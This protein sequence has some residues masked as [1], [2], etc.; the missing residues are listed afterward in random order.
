MKRN[1]CRLI[2][3][4]AREEF[5]PYKTGV[6]RLLRSNQSETVP[7]FS[8]VLIHGGGTDN[9]AISWYK[10]FEPFGKCYSVTALD[11][12]GFGATKGIELLGG[13]DK[14][15]DFTVEIMKLA[16]INKAVVFGV[17]MGG[18]VALNIAL[19]HTSF[20]EALVLVGPG[21]LVPLIKN[22]VLHTSAWLGTK[23]PDWLLLPLSQFANRFV[24]SVLKNMVH[25]YA[26]LPP[27]VVDEFIREAQKRGAGMGYGRYNQATVG[28]YGMKNNLLPLVGSIEVPALFFHGKNDPM[29]DPAGSVKAVNSMPN[30][31]LV[32]PEDCGH[33]AQLEKHEL[34]VHEVER[35]LQGMVY[36]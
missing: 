28:R 29:V 26:A 22:K 23:L 20:T 19:R 5:I 34:F 18:D 12:P 6:V 21:G 1:T 14:M 9:A 4:G 13:P 35:F 24:K 27:E 10:L 2:P 16:D 15:A 7:E 30:A 31:R 25:D 3:P 36:S 8:L 32:M 17:S 33:W 11:L